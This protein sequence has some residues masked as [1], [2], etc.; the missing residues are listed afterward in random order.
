MGLVPPQMPPTPEA[1]AQEIARLSDEIRA[2][3]RRYYQADAPSIS[4]AQYDQLR[5]RLEAIEE[6]FPEL[7]TPASPT[8]KVGSAPAE[9]FGKLR[10]S[11]PMLS[12]DNAFSENDLHEWDARLFE[13]W[14]G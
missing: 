8:Q 4:D 7:V 10:H 1:A 9:G 11:K 5:Q 2:H 12:L 13:A 6:Q 14:C 3:D